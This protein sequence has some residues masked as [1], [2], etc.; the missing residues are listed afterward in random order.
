MSRLYPSR[1]RRFGCCG[2]CA[3]CAVVCLI[4][5]VGVD[6]ADETERAKRVLLI[7]TGSR[8]SPGFALV[9]QG[10]LE[11]LGKIPSG[12]VETYAENL[13]ILRFP[14]ERF[15]QIFTEEQPLEVR[16]DS[17]PMFD[18]RALKRWGISEGQLPPNSSVR[19]RQ[20]SVW[21]QYSW[22]ILGALAIICLQSAMIVDFLLQ[23]RRRHPSGAAREP[24][25]DGTC[26]QRCRGGAVVA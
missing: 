20:P 17:V 11:A 12:R 22:Y 14:T 6:A 16:T 26:H 13:D 15:Q 21:E 4:V 3:L 2:I 24:A 9:D 10:V 18:W 5:T 8:L 25:I 1:I 7:S 19:F 23:R